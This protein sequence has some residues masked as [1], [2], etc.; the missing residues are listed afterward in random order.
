MKVSL[1]VVTFCGLGYALT[2]LLGHMP[3]IRWTAAAWALATVA[4][5]W[6][7]S[8]VMAYDRVRSR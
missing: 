6:A 5:C 1:W 3:V 4:S 2:V 8:A 7:L